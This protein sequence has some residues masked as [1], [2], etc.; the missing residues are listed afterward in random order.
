MSV[1]PNTNS[2]YSGVEKPTHLTHAKKSLIS[3][4]CSS[5]SIVSLYQEPFIEPS[6]TVADNILGTQNPPGIN[7]E[8]SNLPMYNQQAQT[9]YHN[10]VYKQDDIIQYV[11]YQTAKTQ[12]V[13]K[14][15][16][17]VNSKYIGI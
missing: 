12:L 3:R 15:S 6:N 17:V 2:K 1:T 4:A 14:V 5:P 9:V 16:Q 10:Q 13:Q 8:Y 7:S 11:P